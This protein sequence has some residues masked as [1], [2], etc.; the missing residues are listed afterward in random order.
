MRGTFALAANAT[1]TVSNTT[2]LAN[3][4]AAFSGLY[5]METWAEEAPARAGGEYAKEITDRMPVSVQWTA[6]RQTSVSKGEL[7]GR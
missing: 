6:T 7:D 4:L 3:G 2:T 5:L 1:L